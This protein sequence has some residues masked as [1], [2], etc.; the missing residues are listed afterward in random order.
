MVRR[1]LVVVVIVVVA[2][3]LAFLFFAPV[4]PLRQM[5]SV[6]FLDNPS[7]CTSPSSSQCLMAAKQV[8]VS[9]YET[10]AYDLFGFGTSPFASPVR[11]TMNGATNV[12][13]FNSTG[14]VVEQEV[15]PSFVSSEPLPLI[16]VGAVKILSLPFG[17]TG[18]SV[19]V[20][21]NGLNE[22]ASVSVGSPS[23]SLG[24]VR[25]I[26]AGDSLAYNVTSWTGPL[27]RPG[28]SLRLTVYA[29][30]CYGFVCLPYQNNVVS[31]VEA[32]PVSIGPPQFIANGVAGPVYQVGA[33]S[34]DPSALPNTGVR[35]TIQVVDAQTTGSLSFWVS[36]CL[37]NNV[38]GQVGYFI[39]EGSL[40]VGFYQA[41]NLTSNTIIARGTTPIGTGEHTFSMYVQNGT[42]W[43]YAVDGV[44]FGTFNMGANSS[45]LNYP[46]YTLSE[47]QNSTAEFPSVTFASVMQVFR[48][49]SWSPVLRAVS[50]GT[51]WFVQGN[52]Q[53]NRLGADEM[54]VGSGIPFG[55]G[56]I[57]G[58]P[59][60]TALWGP[61]AAP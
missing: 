5:E 49:G 12:L 28:D 4:V 34:T 24:E 21:N 16:S 17:G 6:Y 13:V 43:A 11:I 56:S 45:G 8:W 3:A 31:V 1:A 59:Q 46:V 25:T 55:A 29:M 9:S 54:A 19:E 50:Y 60:G 23:I 40:P 58:I 2:A 42:T 32:G 52:L 10:F 51:A 38:W 37:S 30:V 26:D 48:S 33:M 35:S 36:D 27:P 14:F 7:L 15:F 22:N 18:L 61:A 39:S 47:S 20:I 57:V 44:V 53:N 41:W